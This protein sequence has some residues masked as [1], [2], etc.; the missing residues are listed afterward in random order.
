MF[1]FPTVDQYITSQ[2]VSAII[3]RVRFGTVPFSL[4]PVP[5]CTLCLDSVHRGIR[6]DIIL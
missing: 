4:P 2:T 5:V 1:F 3:G 6:P